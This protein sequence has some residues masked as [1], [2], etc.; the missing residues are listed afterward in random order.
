M[1]VSLIGQDITNT[2]Q[3]CYKTHHIG[4]GITVTYSMFH[5][6]NFFRIRNNNSAL[7]KIFQNSEELVMHLFCRSLI[8]SMS[9]A[10]MELHSVRHTA[11]HNDV[12]TYIE[13]NV[14]IYDLESLISY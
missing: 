12:R 9:V 7:N 3:S 5:K 2:S 13:N 14:I 11:A 8:V 6:L 10:C 1:L 4:T